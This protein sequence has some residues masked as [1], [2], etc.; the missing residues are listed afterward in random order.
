M[1]REHFIEY[2]GCHI[3]LA[4]GYFEVYE[5]VKRLE[6][7][8]RNFKGNVVFNIDGKTYAMSSRHRT[9]IEATDYIERYY[10]DKYNE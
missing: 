6:D 7:T 3:V 8:N 5:Y 10:K 4:N 2:R 9:L 1:N